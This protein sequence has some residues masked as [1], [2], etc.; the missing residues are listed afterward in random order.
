VVRLSMTLT[1][2]VLAVL[3]SV[4]FGQAEN[5][6]NDWSNSWSSTS[7]TDRVVKLQQA[8]I[9]RKGESG[10]YKNLGKNITNNTNTVYNQNDTRQGTFNDVNNE[11][12]GDVSIVSRH[13]D[14]IGQNTN[15]IGAVNNS[16]NTISIDGK[17]NTINASN[18]AT[19]TGCQD[20]TISIATIDSIS[21]APSS[22]SGS[23]DC[24]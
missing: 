18:A 7:S 2:A 22:S 15:V 12:D 1:A 24:N 3:Q 13:G 9:I 14:D 11:G 8:D 4:T 23:A 10:Y 17:G 16:S 5:A 20:G 21:G 19:S 6:G